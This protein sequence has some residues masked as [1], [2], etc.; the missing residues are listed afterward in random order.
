[1]LNCRTYLGYI[2]FPKKLEVP[3]T[4]LDDE[5]FDRET[6][7][8]IN[9]DVQ[10]FELEV[11]K[12]MKKILKQNTLREIF[13]EIHFALLK[14]LLDSN[15]TTYVRIHRF[16]ITKDIF[17]EKNIFGHEISKSFEIIENKGS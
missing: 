9:M 8:F 3:I 14:N 13:L 7:N 11:L 10:G 5:S 2:T 4:K 6:F 15:D 1:M 12:G 17:E 16:Y